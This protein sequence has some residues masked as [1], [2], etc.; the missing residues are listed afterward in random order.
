MRYYY[1]YL[2]TK[3]KSLHFE[4]KNSKVKN[5]PGLI[6]VYSHIEKSFR[7]YITEVESLL[8]KEVKNKTVKILFFNVGGFNNFYYTNDA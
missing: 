8:R 4:I 5:R 2:S 1:Y 3:Y 7:V 6:V